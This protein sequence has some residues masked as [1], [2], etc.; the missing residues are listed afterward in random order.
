MVGVVGTSAGFQ[1]DPLTGLL[2]IE[3][4]HYDNHVSQGGY[5]WT[6]VSV[7][8]ASGSGSLQALPN[9]RTNNNSGYESNSP[10]LD[11][12]VN[13]TQVGT[14]YVW[15]RGQAANGDDDSLHVGLNGIG[16]SSADKITRFTSSWS[17]RDDTKD[18]VRATLEVTT[19][20]EQLLNIWMREDGMVIDKIMLT[21]NA[22]IQPTDFGSQGPDES[23]KG[24]Q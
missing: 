23:P 6:A 17:W 9:N 1:Q 19:P 22:S 21:T 8:G 18:K 10:R 2:S 12:L 13:F 3:V 15:I 24:M 14:H 4:E 11:Y 7:S 20:G 5:D 16:Q